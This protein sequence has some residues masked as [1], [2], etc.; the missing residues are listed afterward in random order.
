MCT[1]IKALFTG[2]GKRL[3]PLLKKLLSKTGVIIGEVVA[4][5]VAQMA[6]RRLAGESWDV[7]LKSAV[8]TALVDLER[9]GLVMG[10]DFFLNEVVAEATAAVA[11]NYAD[12]VE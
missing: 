6:T 2:A 11:K 10:V 9:K 7:V 5:S 4:A 1:W 12:K 8:D 3:L